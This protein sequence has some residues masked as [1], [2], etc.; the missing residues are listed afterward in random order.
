MLWSSL[1]RKICCHNHL[2]LQ[3]LI[4]LSLCTR[5]RSGTL[6]VVNT[7]TWEHEQYEMGSPTAPPSVSRSSSTP[8]LRPILGASGLMA[9][10]RD[11]NSVAW[12]GVSAGT[13]GDSVLVRQ[14][15]A[16]LRQVLSTEHL[17]ER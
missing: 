14:A 1:A 6:T 3:T 13:E 4:A 16:S 11:S 2:I 10:Q 5:K 8:L 15:P 12:L 17:T 9:M 7:L